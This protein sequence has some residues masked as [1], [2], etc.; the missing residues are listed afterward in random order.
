L[1]QFYVFSKFIENSSKLIEKSLKIHRK[2]TGQL[3]SWAAGQL[4]SW[5]AGHW[6]AGQLGNWAAGQ[7]GSWLKIPAS[8]PKIPIVGFAPQLR[9]SAG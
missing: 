9:F 4:G 7:L 5:A 3:G 1:G 6:A 2:L 8:R